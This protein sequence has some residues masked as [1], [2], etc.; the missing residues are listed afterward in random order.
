[1]MGAG[2]VSRVVAACAAM[3][4]CLAGCSRKASESIEPSALASAAVTVAAGPDAAT[5]KPFGA[6][7]V[8]DSEGAG[9]VC[10]HKRLKV[11]DAGKERRGADDP[12]E[13]DGY[14]SLRCNDDADC[15]VPLT[16]G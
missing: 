4:L 5:G 8:A 1:M 10:F 2:A 16:K 11:P 14:C 3:A 7:C 12:V 15:P 9:G 13:H 6:Y